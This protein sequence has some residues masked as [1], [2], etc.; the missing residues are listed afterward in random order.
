MY[1]CHLFLF[2]GGK[3]RVLY[4]EI[5]ARHERLRERGRTSCHAPFSVLIQKK[6]GGKK[7]IN[8]LIQALKDPPFRKPESGSS[9]IL[10][11]MIKTSKQ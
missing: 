6:R 8:N 10:M 9:E 5:R 2:I 4:I 3:S 1:N 7:A 11:Y